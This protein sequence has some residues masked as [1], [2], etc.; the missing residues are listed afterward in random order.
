MLKG[1]GDVVE[2]V[3]SSKLQLRLGEYLRLAILIRFIPLNH[4]LIVAFDVSLR[5]WGVDG[6]EYTGI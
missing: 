6:V 5:A 3:G 4:A 2:A 1:P